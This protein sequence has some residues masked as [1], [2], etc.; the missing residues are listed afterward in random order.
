M[1]GP[2]CKLHNDQGA[3]IIPFGIFGDQVWAALK[4]L[5]YHITVVSRDLRSAINWAPIMPI[6]IIL[7]EVG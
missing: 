4:P 5:D 2:A 7:P 6:V 3:P 1:F